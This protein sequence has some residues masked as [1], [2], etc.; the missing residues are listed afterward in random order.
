ME[1][2][3]EVVETVKDKPTFSQF[4]ESCREIAPFKSN[5]VRRKDQ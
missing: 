1:R 4:E 2:I 3:Q 5:S